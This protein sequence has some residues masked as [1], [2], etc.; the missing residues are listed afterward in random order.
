MVHRLLLLER[1]ELRRAWPFFALYLVLFAALALADGLT[2]A[3]FVRRV[4]ARELPLFLA[5]AAAAVL[6]AMLIYLRIAQRLAAP[7]LFAVVL[8]LPAAV[9][10]CVW[11]GIRLDLLPTR[12]LGLLLLGR[13]LSFALVLLHFG[14]FLQDYFTRTELNRVMSFIYAGGRVGGMAGGALLEHLSGSVDPIDLLVVPV[15]LLVVGIAAVAWLARRTATVP[16]PDDA[17]SVAV[18]D[19][20]AAGLALPTTAATTAATATAATATAATGAATATSTA[21]AATAATTPVTIAPRAVTPE[22]AVATTATLGGFLGF[23]W[24]SPLLF[25]ITASTIVYFVCRVCLNVQYS[26][27]FEQLLTD[28]AEL[29]RFL[30][31]YTQA[32]L[33]ISLVLQLLVVNRLVAWLGMRGAQL[34]YAALVLVAAVACWGEMSLAAAVFVRFV[35]GELRFGLRNPVAQM[36]VNQFPK[37]L[38]TRAR[39]WSLGVLIPLSTL[40]GSLLLI[41]LVRSSQPAALGLAALVAGMAY[42]AASWAMTA[43]LAAPLPLAPAVVHDQASRPSGAVTGRARRPAARLASQPIASAIGPHGSL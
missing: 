29:A 38:R 7:R 31:R 10:A 30:G 17:P 13:E 36:I 33:A 12:G 26:A 8:A 19:P 14:A 40:A 9:F 2:L 42:L 32:A 28:E 15:T 43:R 18:A 4:G 24:R 5:V 23:V 34:T 22:E 16:E 27:C 20:M 11:L 35:E 3:L 37:P 6:P 41:A 1:G 39:A 21:A 25:W